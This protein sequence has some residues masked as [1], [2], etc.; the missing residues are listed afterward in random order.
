MYSI[1]VLIK[2]QILYNLG[3]IS[4]LNIAVLENFLKA[5]HHSKTINN[6]CVQI[7]TVNIFTFN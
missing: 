6:F 2:S 5:I 3:Y 1:Y 7:I 4:A